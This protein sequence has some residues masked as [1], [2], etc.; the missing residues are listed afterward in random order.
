MFEPSTPNSAAANAYRLKRSN[1]EYDVAMW[2]ACALMALHKD[3]PAAL[4]EY[5]CLWASRAK[6]DG[7]KRSHSEQS[8][9]GQ[10]GD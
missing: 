6:L 8:S 1:S 4:Q 10:P 5:A 7:S 3:E 2:A 9:S